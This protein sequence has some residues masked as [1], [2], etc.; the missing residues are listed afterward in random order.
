MQQ[1]FIKD[2]EAGQR[3]DKFLVKHL[4]ECNQSFIFKMLR[5][6][7][8]TLNEKK[9]QGK[10]ILQVGDLICFFFTDET[11][12]KFTAI[13]IKN[14]MS[15]MV[16]VTPFKSAFQNIGT[17]PIV[18]ENNH[19]LIVNK[20]AGVLSQ[21]ATAEDESLNEW[22]IGYLLHHKHIVQ[23]DLH[24]FKPSICNRLDRNTTGMI[25]CGKTL[26]G[27]QQL[28]AHLK[29]RSLHKYYRCLVL[30]QIEHSKR[31]EGYLCKDKKTNKV[32]ITNAPIEK[33]SEIITNYEPIVVTKNMTLLEVELITGKTHQIRA[34]LASIGHPIIGDIKYGYQKTAPL[35]KFS[36]K[37]QLLH[38]YR[39]E[40]PISDEDGIPS[41]VSIVCEPPEIYNQL[42]QLNE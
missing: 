15:T 7:N 33:Y 10:E 4:K 2:N 38:S 32:T 5:K 12:E 42:L 22:F 35:S 9:A 13:S 26:K 28:S 34:H 23:E 31:L 3:F 27:T 17:L 19:V 1:I 8:I 6:K 30:G 20:P 39:L 11:Y 18:F 25:L 36:L 16:D 14:P 37:H 29:A 41:G 24:T 40:F 21:K